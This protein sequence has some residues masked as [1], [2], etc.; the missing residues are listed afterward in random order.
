MLGLRRASGASRPV[1]VVM[2]LTFGDG[3]T[4]EVPKNVHQAFA[5]LARGEASGNQQKLVLRTL[6]R[7]TQPMGFA[8]CK[9]SER[10][11]GMSD[12]ARIVGQQIATMV[13]GEEPW[14]LKYL[15]DITNDDGHA[16]QD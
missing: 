1:V 10:M 4:E 5:A 9:A 8:D 6:F 14:T 16:G 11:A 2:N 13:G 15:G 3:H 12:G 7:I